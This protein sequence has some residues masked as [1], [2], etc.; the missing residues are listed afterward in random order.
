MFEIIINKI[1]QYELELNKFIASKFFGRKYIRTGSCKACGKCCREIYVRH[2]KHVITEEEEFEMLKSQHFFY[3]YLKVI[4]KNET[5]LI[6]ECTKLDKEKGY[7]TAYNKRALIC[8][9]YP[10]EEIFMMGGTISEE[11]GFKFIPIKSFEE[12]FYSV[13]KRKVIN[14]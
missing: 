10:Q 14:K 1:K 12:V 9:M 5:G 8:R 3:S 4:G 13:K 6:F 7:C 2:T 11:C